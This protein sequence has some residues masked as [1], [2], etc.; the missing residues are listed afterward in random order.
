MKTARG[1]KRSPA[2]L[3]RLFVLGLALYA[4]SALALHPGKRISQ[5]GLTRWTA[6]KGLPQNDVKSIVQTTDGYLWLATD[7]GLARF[8]GFRF[9]TYNK[10]NTPGFPSSSIEA[11]A[12]DPAG[13]LWA[14]SSDGL[15]RFIGGEAVSAGAPAFVGAPAIVGAPEKLLR[16]RITSLALGADGCVYAGSTAGLLRVC[17]ARAERIDGLND[18]MILALAAGLK[19]EIWIAT[20]GKGLWRYWNGELRDMSPSGDKAFAKPSKLFLDSAGRLWVAF[21]NGGLWRA[22]PPELLDSE[23]VREGGTRAFTAFTESPTG[24]VWAGTA[25]G[26][27]CR[28]DGQGIEATALPLASKARAVHSLLADRE[29]NVWVG[30]WSDGLLRLRD[31]P[32]ETFSSEE[33]LA[34]DEFWTVM[35]DREGAIWAGSI[36]GGV[37]RLKDGKVQT[38]TRAQGLPSDNVRSLAPGPDSSIWVGFFD[39]PLSLLK[40]GSASI[41]R[42]PDGRTIGPA[43]SLFTARDGALW[44]GNRDCGVCRLKDGTLTSLHELDGFPRVPGYV[45]KE[46]ES[47]DIWVGTG[48][49]GLVRIRGGHVK[50]FRTDDGLPT[51]SVMDF[52]QDA[53]GKLWIA[54]DGGGLARLDERGIRSLGLSEG[55]PDDVLHSI[56]E[57]GEG[58]LWMSTN[59]GLV[60]VRKTE[61]EEVLDGREKTVTSTVLGVSAG[62][63]SAEGTGSTQPNSV[64]ARNGALWFTTI[65]GIVT[66]KPES[67]RRPSLEPEAVIE[68]V[69][70]GALSLLPGQDSLKVPSGKGP[71]EVQYTGLLFRQAEELEFR[72]R[73]EGLETEWT[74]A[75]SRREAFFTHIPAG[76]YRFRVE[77]RRKNGPWQES[78]KSIRV[79]VTPRPFET[80]WFRAGVLFLLGA[81]GVGLVKL[82]VSALERRREE[83][84]ERVRD[85]T[86]DVESALKKEAEARAEA[87]A[88]RRRSEEAN[89]AKSMFLASMSHELRTPLNAILGFVQVM[90]RTKARSAEDRKYLEIIS[91]SGEHL[92]ALIN[93]VLSISKIEA[94]QLE[95]RRKPFSLRDLLRNAAE[96]VRPRVEAKDLD[97]DLELSNSIPPL[98]L[99]DEPRIR[100][101]VLNL[102]SNAAK[103][104]QKGSIT[105]RADWQGGR[106]KIEVEDTGGGLRPGEKDRLFEA[107]VQTD[108]GWRSGEG[109]GL[110]L[111]ISQR[112]IRLMGGELEVESRP[113]AGTRFWF[114]L[115]MPEAR[116]H[117]SKPAARR[118]I[119]LARGQVPRKVMVADDTDENRLLLAEMQ[120]A[121]GLTVLEANSGEMAVTLW[122]TEKPDLV[123]LDDR[124]PGLAGTEVLQRIRERE[125]AAGRG[126]VPVIAVTASAFEENTAKLMAAGF[127]DV[128]CKPFRHGEIFDLLSRHLNLEFVFEEISGDYA[129][130]R[131]A[132]SN[133][134]LGTVVNIPK[135]LR[136]RLRRAAVES[137]LAAALEAIGEIETADPPTAKT[138]RELAEA[139]RFEEI[140]GLV[141]GK[142]TE[143]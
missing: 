13:G 122:E 48:G 111:T 119:G 141:G 143:P 79:L 78:R 114:S 94:G 35:E 28:F 62:M 117:V 32:V 120:R 136:D 14:G 106:V 125:K 21:A 41:Y 27:L 131:R 44:F 59:H 46:D 95:I 82:R 60:T 132:R 138:L 54:T 105:L 86:R 6:E 19:G 18:T 135:E 91:N 5:Y 40:D 121:T 102:L 36:G 103:F 20:R 24:Y 118:V 8:D 29:G 4:G 100:Q 99:G 23:V 139:F 74:E 43:W 87:E 68:S 98:V 113:G 26:E 39:A 129:S 15:I 115:E 45:I 33:G 80:V 85:R 11:L 124:M 58:N 104:T 75:S 37:S 133:E 10:R 84:E 67:F 142:R 49:E 69:R 126:R 123:W 42:L 25:D 55:L 112:L 30:T 83:L 71:I 73:F 77:V 72:Y 97:L 137:D 53:N 88:E 140:E 64:R 107:F 34:G 1:S 130:R 7:D 63:K 128:L 65:K 108:A 50:I 89:R 96:M 3:C 31:G 127:D 70:A 110:G 51:G 47:G 93:D 90:V 52:Y 16:Q 22:R 61:A 81:A 92:L 57:D 2:T 101:V 66:L 116:G 12:A 76:D 134:I 9:R 38:F 109:S 56:L 17:R